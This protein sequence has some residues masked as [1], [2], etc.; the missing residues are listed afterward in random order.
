MTV[1]STTNK[2]SYN[3]NGSQSVFAYGFKIFADTDIQVYVGTTLKTLST[4]YT[5]SG[6]GAAGGGNVTFTTGNIPASGTGN[7]TILRSLALTQG[8]DLVNYGRF[9]AEVIESQYDK[10]VMMVQQLQEQADR[11][12]RFNTTV[13][14]AGGVEIT[15]TV[16]ERSNKVLAYDNAGDLSVANELGE[17]KGNWATSTAFAPRDLVLDAATNNVYICLVAHT[18]GTLS[19]DVSSSKWALV[20][21]ASAVA[22]SATTATT[23]ASEAAASA[24]TASNQASTSTTQANTSTAQASIATTKANTATTKAA[25]AT[26]KASEASTSASNAAASASTASTQ[27]TNSSNSASAGSTSATN[28]A[29]SATAAA[30][31]ASTATTKA[32]SATA[33]ASTASTQATN[34]SNSATASANSATASANSATASGNS[35]TAA[36]SSAST[37]TTKRNESSA[38]ATAAANSAAAA[39]TALDSFDDRYLGAKSSAPG[40]DNDGNALVQGALYFDTSANGMKV[41][42]GSA[43]IAASSSGT[44]SLLTYKYIATNNQT[45]F[46]GSDANSV[47]LTYTAT[48]ILVLLNG[49]TLDASDYTATN[50]SSIVLGAGATTGSELVVVAF[51]SFTVADHYTKSQANALLAAKAPIASPVF[52][53]NVGLGV[54]PETWN[55][56]WDVL[57]VG[58]AGVFAGRTDSANGIDLGSNFWFE[59][60]ASSFKRIVSDKA[61]RYNSFNGTHVF[62]VAATGAVDSAISWTTGLEVLNDGKARAKNGLLF[63]TDTAAANTLDDYEEGTFTPTVTATTSGTVAYTQQVGT[64]TKIGNMVTVGIYVDF[65]ESNSV[66]QYWIANLPFT[67][68]VE[69]RGVPYDWYIP[70]GVPLTNT[71]LI[72]SAN[73]TYFRLFCTQS[74]SFDGTG[75]AFTNLFVNNRCALWTNFSYFTNS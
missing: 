30:S 53:G 21:N 38:S 68:S 11:T 44:A 12:I 40:Q 55:T 10:L 35:A 69:A 19:S 49:I 31:S 62:Q 1:S 65:T 20:I 45:T 47:T 32:N 52:T 4:H 9:D 60:S 39:A 2:Q 5:L 28:S 61:S 23:K 71:N 70:S 8:V 17:W 72:L 13:S 51:K 24:T 18:S 41:Y 6:V 36:A 46:T 64:Y 22:A 42:D 33:S 63:G 3:G 7:V 27:A 29:N 34:S 54:V 66:G 16:A 67:S 59:A 25:T 26:T 74:A 73:A 43:W 57:Q 58:N 15:D 75:E 48:N 37:A 56:A 14:D 50:G